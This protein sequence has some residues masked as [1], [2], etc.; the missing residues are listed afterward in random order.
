MK[1]TLIKEA[2]FEFNEEKY[3]AIPSTVFDTLIGKPDEAVLSAS[4]LPK[5]VMFEDKNDYVQ[6]AAKH[7]I[8]FNRSIY[9][10]NKGQILCFLNTFSS[11]ESTNSKENKE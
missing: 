8:D 11:D 7:E 1:I 9:V 4:P 10:S 3:T 5:M 6:N 2:N